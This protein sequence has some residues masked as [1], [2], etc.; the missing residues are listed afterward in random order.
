V[1]AGWRRALM[2]PEAAATVNWHW[3][4]ADT[5]GGWG[6]ETLHAQ[7]QQKDRGLLCHR[8]SLVI[9]LLRY[10]LLCDLSYNTPMHCQHRRW[11]WDWEIG[12]AIYWAN[13]ASVSGLYGKPSRRLISDLSPRDTPRSGSAGGLRRGRDAAD[14]L[15]ALAQVNYR[16]LTRKWSTQTRRWT[17]GC[18]SRR[19]Q[20]L[21]ILDGREI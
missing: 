2:W 15:Q 20:I 14:L 17:K 13:E 6:Q 3:Q 12:A 10:I 11:Y 5:C 1:R 19:I 21:G 18:L 7:Q 8:Y 16:Q 9:I 4:V